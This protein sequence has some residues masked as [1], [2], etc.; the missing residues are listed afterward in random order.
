MP[1]APSLSVVRSSP[2]VEVLDAAH[3]IHVTR[4]HR[5]GIGIPL[6]VLWG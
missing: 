3:I 5:A 2:L 4:V 1:L 6:G